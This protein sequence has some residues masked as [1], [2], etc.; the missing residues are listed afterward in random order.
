MIELT[1]DNSKKLQEILSKRFGRVLSELELKEAY[2][3]LM[4]FAIALIQIYPDKTIDS[5]KY[6]NSKKAKHTSIDIPF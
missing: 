4:D 6:P 3:G 5:E 2:T 1:K